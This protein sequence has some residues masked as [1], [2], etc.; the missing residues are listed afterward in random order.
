MKCN[1]IFYKYFILVIFIILFVWYFSKN[2]EGFNPD[3]SSIY[4]ACGSPCSVLPPQW[5]GRLDQGNGRLG[6]DHLSGFNFYNAY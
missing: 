4:N 2:K 5:I 3:V 1:K 6:D